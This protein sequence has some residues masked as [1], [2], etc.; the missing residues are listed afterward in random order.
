MASGGSGVRWFQRELAAGAALDVL[1]AEAAATPPGAEGV[2][3]LPYLL[4]EKTPRQRPARDRRDRRACSS[5]TAR[6]HLF[7]ALL[8]SFAYGVRHH[9]EVLAEHGVRPAR[10][11]VTNG[12]ASSTLWKQIVADVTGLVL[13]PVVDHPGSALGAAF[14]AGMGTG[15]FAEWSDIARFVA[16]RGARAPARRDGSRLRRGLPRLPRAVRPQAV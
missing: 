14:A 16:A 15:A 9:L 2:V 8:E 4:G 13:E 1:D 12:G 7:R 10:A 11:R 3:V 6:G 5:A